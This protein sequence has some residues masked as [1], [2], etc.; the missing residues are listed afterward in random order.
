MIMYCFLALTNG[1]SDR[2]EIFQLI[3]KDPYEH[4]KFHLDTIIL[5]K[6]QFLTDI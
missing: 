2:T 4:A 1:R 6:R 5:G 3:L